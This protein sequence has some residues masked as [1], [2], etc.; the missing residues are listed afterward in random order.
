MTADANR[1]TAKAA[2]MMET[3][4]RG[5]VRAG[6]EAARR[7]A[8]RR[9][10]EPKGRFAHYHIPTDIFWQG[11]QNGGGLDAMRPSSDYFKDMVRRHPEL[12]DPH[13]IQPSPHKATLFFVDGK[14]VR[15]DGTV[16][17]KAARPWWDDERTTE[18]T[19]RTERKNA[20]VSS[21]SSVVER[22][23]Q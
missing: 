12:G 17:P 14:W 4:R 5:R 18:H 8:K 11:V 23:A 15:R 19:E 9:Q 13:D 6:W 16:V 10:N 21:A 1:T 2:M 20:S 7:L 22:K 3:E